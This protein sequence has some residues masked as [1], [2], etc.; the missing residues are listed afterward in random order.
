[1]A[2]QDKNKKRVL[3][4]RTPGPPVLCS[5]L[6]GIFRL[7]NIFLIGIIDDIDLVDL[8]LFR[9]DRIDTIIEIEVLDDQGPL[10]IFVIYTKSLLHN[11]IL[12]ADINISCIISNDKV[13]N[14]SI[15]IDFIYI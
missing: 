12:Q 6:V 14:F 3:S 11:G 8:T 9:S 13:I 10:Q 5:A 4:Y 15:I 1:M 7:N 2:E